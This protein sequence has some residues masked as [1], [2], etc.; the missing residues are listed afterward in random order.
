MI[1]LRKYGIVRMTL[2]YV[3][4]LIV[5]ATL[6]ACDASPSQF[7]QDLDLQPR[8]YGVAPPN[9]ILFIGNSFTYYNGG[10]D[11]HL[12]KLVRAAYPESTILI[13]SL[14]TPNQTVEGHFRSPVT[15]A[16]LRRPWDVVVVQG[17]S[18][19]PLGRDT[20]DSFDQHMVLIANE[21]RSRDAEVALF[22]TWAYRSRPSMIDDLAYAYLKSGNDISALVVPVGLAWEEVR[23]QR[24]TS[25]LY[26]DR[27]HPSLHGT[28]LAACVFYSALFGETPVG[29]PYTAG[30]LEPD[31]RYLQEVAARTTQLFYARETVTPAASIIP[32]TEADRTNSSLL[33]VDND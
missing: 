3:A 29:I 2:K 30:L 26:S 4:I 21:I 11:F 28:Y 20:L 19:E 12:R 27:K 15:H 9:R 33:D 8:V 23:R 22:M 24:S 25:Y 5:A 7:A 32:R 31:A 14:T 13:D 1:A 6:I 18:Y 17:A 16:T 10:V